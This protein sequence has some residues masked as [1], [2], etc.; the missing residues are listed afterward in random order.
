MVKTTFNQRRKTLRNNIRP[1]L[2]ELAPDADHS[3]FLADP[4]FNLRP[5]QLSLEQFIALTRQVTALV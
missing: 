4:L 3:A 1:I 5:E 2:N